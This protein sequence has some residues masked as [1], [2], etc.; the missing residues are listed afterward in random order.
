MLATYRTLKTDP[1]ELEKRIAS[2]FP[3]AGISEF[4]WGGCTAGFRL[5]KHFRGDRTTVHVHSTPGDLRQPLRALADPAGNL[6]LMKAFGA[7]NW[8]AGQETVH[9][10]LVYSEMLREGSERAREAAQEVFDEFIRPGW[11]PES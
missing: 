8:H 5:T 6:V 4:R 9:P 3:S 10:L 2:T 1:D 7:I 11:E